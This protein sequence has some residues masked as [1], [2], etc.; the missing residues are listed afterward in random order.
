MKKLLFVVICIVNFLSLSAQVGKPR[1]MVFPARNWMIEKGYIKGSAAS[2]EMDYQRALDNNKE[3][4][5]VINTIN[6]LMTERGFPLESLAETLKQ[7]A[8]NNALDNM[9]QNQNGEGIA[10][11]ARDKI[12]KTA[13]PDITLEIT[14]TINQVG[15]KRSVTFDMVGLNAATAKQVAGANGVG[16]QSFTP[17]LPILLKEAVLAHLDNFNSQLQTHFQDMFDN[18]REISLNVKV[19]ADSPKKLNDEVND[20]GDELKDAIIDW[21]KKNT[22]KGR[23]SL[24]TSSPNMMSLKQVRIPL[25]AEDGSSFDADQFAAALRKYLKK[26]FQLPSESSAIGL[27]QGEIVIGGKRN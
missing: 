23:Y 18:G 3:L 4:Y 15:P 26:N 8:E 7:L 9:D 1:I 11:S 27:G 5:S 17:E 14:W 20:D 12:L 25:L 10:E 19:W 24:A 2:P 16:P 21:I 6:T 22:V 13:R